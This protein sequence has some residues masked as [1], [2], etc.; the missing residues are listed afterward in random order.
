MSA[1]QCLTPKQIYAGEMWTGKG[2]LVSQMLMIADVSMCSVLL[3]VS[4]VV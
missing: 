3:S 4:L 2:Y 1:N